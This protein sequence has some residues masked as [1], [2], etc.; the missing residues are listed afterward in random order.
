MPADE[1]QQGDQ[2]AETLRARAERIRLY[3]LTDNP[4]LL[5]LAKGETLAGV[6][7]TAE[8]TLWLSLASTK[9]VWVALLDLAEQLDS[10]L[11]GQ[12]KHSRFQSSG[13]R[14]GIE[15]EVDPAIQ[16]AKHVVGRRG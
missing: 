7:L 1:E 9:A 14:P 12:I 15:H 13:S 11:G 4:H 5:A 3:E 2:P 10:L 8:D 16:A 6:T